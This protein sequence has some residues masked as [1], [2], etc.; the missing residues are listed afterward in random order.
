MEAQ[1]LN[2]MSA[3]KTPSFENFKNLSAEHKF[4]RSKPGYP[5]RK[6]FN[7][8]PSPQESSL[9]TR[10]VDKELAY[11]AIDTQEDYVVERGVVNATALK[12]AD[13]SDRV[14]DDGADSA[15]QYFLQQ[16][17]GV[18]QIQATAEESRIDSLEEDQIVPQISE[19]AEIEDV[20]KTQT[21]YLQG[22]SA[23]SAHGDDSPKVFQSL[24]ETVLQ[25]PS[26]PPLNELPKDVAQEAMPQDVREIFLQIR[27]HLDAGEIDAMS[28]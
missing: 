17:Q 1:K 8:G 14:S 25:T 18:V 20:E 11:K 3:A 21:E 4:S 15:V 5:E 6:L 7:L 22:S 26:A 9:P 13:H 27:K 19:N 23:H 24:A 16:T 28:E 10:V 2:K 12:S